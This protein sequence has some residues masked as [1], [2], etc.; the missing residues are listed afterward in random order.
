MT[1][2]H[3]AVEFTQVARRG[4]LVDFLAERCQAG[5]CV[6]VS[7]GCATR[8]QRIPHHFNMPVSRPKRT[9]SGVRIVSLIGARAGLGVGFGLARAVR[10]RSAQA[11]VGLP[12]ARQAS[13]KAR[14]RLET[15][16]DMRRRPSGVCLPDF[17]W[18][19]CILQRERGPLGP[20]TTRA[21]QKPPAL[22][23]ASHDGAQVFLPAILIFAR[24]AHV[25]RARRQRQAR[26]FGQPDPNVVPWPLAFG[27]MDEGWVVAWSPQLG[28]G[29]ARIGELTSSELS[30]IVRSTVRALAI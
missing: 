15:A 1:F 5:D 4:D 27:T 3:K 25:A 29:N 24:K 9:S 18:P 10:K 17:R 19:P 21:R 13:Q 11:S 8:G 7:N 2:L 26:F 20:T 30:G 16:S 6:F 14:M 22:V 12:A 23:R 28:T